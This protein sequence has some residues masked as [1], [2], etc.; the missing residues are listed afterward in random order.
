M[1][2]GPGDVQPF[3]LVTLVE[4]LG[5]FLFAGLDLFFF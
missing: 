2:L 3:G 1:G 5:D 4:V